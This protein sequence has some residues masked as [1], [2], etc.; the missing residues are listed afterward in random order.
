MFRNRNQILIIAIISAAISGAAIIPNVISA[1]SSSS[2]KVSP[3]IVSQNE[4]PAPN[5]LN[6]TE[7]QKQQL[8]KLNE[9]TLQLIQAE[10]TPEQRTRF[11]AELKKGDRNA[12]WRA[13]NLTR[14]QRERIIAI[15][16]TANEER[17]TIFT[18]EQRSQVEKRRASVPSK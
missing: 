17:E 10:L 6:L 7:V 8:R 18:A 15:N 12:A 2:S 3:S 1:Q 16:K 4:K 14:G 13:M 9:E 11:A 5:P